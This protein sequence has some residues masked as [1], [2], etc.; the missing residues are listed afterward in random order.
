ME[1]SKKRLLL[2]SL[3]TLA[4]S[5]TAMASPGV[6]FGVGLGDAKLNETGIDDE[7]GKKFFAGYKINRFFAVEAGYTD[8]GSFKSSSIGTT[9]ELDGLEATILASYPIG[10]RF[11]VFGRLGLWN[12]DFET[13]AATGT[14]ISSKDGRD[15]VHGIGADFNLNRRIKLRGSWDEY[16]VDNGIANLISLNMVYKF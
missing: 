5:N 10:S 8:F 7:T 6:Y 4:V 12:W 11:S 14:K 15:T 9:A 2:A 1:I 3:I 16:R 13:A